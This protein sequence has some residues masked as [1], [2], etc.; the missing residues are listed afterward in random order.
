MSQSNSHHCRASRSSWR[1]RVLLV[2]DW[3]VNDGVVR[4]KVLRLSSFE[5]YNQGGR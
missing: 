4:K 3:M 2:V 5:Y 1:A